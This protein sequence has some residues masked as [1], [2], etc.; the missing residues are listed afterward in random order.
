MPAFPIRKLTAM[1]HALLILSGLA[2]SPALAATVE[3]YLRAEATT[4]SMPDG[5]II[6]MWGFAQDSGFGVGDGTI[7]IPG[8]QI[9]AAAGDTL[10]IHLDNNLPVPVSIVIPSQI[11]A[12]TPV[13]LPDPDGTGRPRVQSFTHET[14]PGNG[15][16]VDYTWTNLKAGT[17]LYESGTHPAVQIQ[18]GLYGAAIVDSGVAGQ[19]YGE[20][21]SAYDVQLTML[22]SE[23]DPALHAAVDDGT[24]VSFGNL[25]DPGVSMTSTVD[26]NPK[27][28]LI[29]GEAYSGST[30]P[31]AAGA[32]GDRVLLRLLNAGLRSRAPF[33]VR[34]RQSLIAEDGNEYAHVKDQAVVRL[35]AGQT[36]DSIVEFTTD[37]DYAFFDRAMGVTN[38]GASPGGM[39]RILQVAP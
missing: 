11:T 33:V 20:T 22:F 15:A 26:Y 19:A 39:F 34:S 7:S 25:G 3:V 32:V 23:L 27:Y 21:S 35:P 6:P 38:A 8:P 14:P 13:F 1:T 4:I 18:M 16:A 36:K 37:G 30:A 5:A 29:N 31:I 24:Y 2:V 10:I 12:M 28:F 17:F 9:N